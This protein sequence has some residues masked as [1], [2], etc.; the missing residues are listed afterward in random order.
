MMEMCV[1]PDDPLLTPN[2]DRFSPVS[3]S[4]LDGVAVDAPCAPSE[5]AELLSLAVH[6]FRTPVTV[7]AGYLRMLSREQLGPLSERQRKVIEEAERACGRL[8]ALV[9]E[10]SELAGLEG[11]GQSPSFTRGAVALGPM[12]DEIASQ[13]L[14]GRDRGVSLARRGD[15]SS[16]TVDGD[17]GRLKAAFGALATAVLREQTDTTEVIL[18]AGVEERDGRRMAVLTIGRVGAAD[19][20]MET[21]GPGARFN[22][23]RGGLG[24]ALPIARRVIERAGGRIWSSAA[25]RTLG[26]VA[27]LLPLKETAS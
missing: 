12:L 27:V 2:G 3:R 26:A 7:V 13:A 20:L 5:Q 1:V 8:S 22:E 4:D 16:V 14:E 15:V 18:Q 25:G 21:G 17:R 11:R 23:F 6:E 24:L 19:M 9:T 10:M